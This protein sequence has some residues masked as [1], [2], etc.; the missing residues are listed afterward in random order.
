MVEFR[1]DFYRLFRG[2]FVARVLTFP[3][4]AVIIVP[5]P[6]SLVRSSAE[7]PLSV[8]QSGDVIVVRNVCAVAA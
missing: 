5:P 8:A 7:E 1:A 3:L 4:P 2:G 6:R